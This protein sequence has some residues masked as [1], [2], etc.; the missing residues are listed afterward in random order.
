M[1]PDPNVNSDEAH[2][3]DRLAEYFSGSLVLDDELAVE[4]HLL[5]C[6]DCRNEY[7][8]LGEIV[9]LIALEHD[10]REE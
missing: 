2:V 6:A 4:G 1:S 9:L 8:R 3:V 5:A 7:D 10:G